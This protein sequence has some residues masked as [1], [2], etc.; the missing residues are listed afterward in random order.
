MV[1]NPNKDLIEKRSRDEPTGEVLPLTSKDMSTRMGD[2]YQRTRPKL[3]DED[4]QQQQAKKAAKKKAAKA[5]ASEMG[6][7]STST[8]TGGASGSEKKFKGQS[9]LSDDFESLSSILYRPKTYETRQSYEIILSFILE[10]IGDQPR[11]I[12]CGAADEILLILKNDRLRD[13]ERKREVES[14]L[15]PLADERFA[16]LVNLGKKLTDWSK[17]SI[18]SAAAAA[19]VANNADGGGGGDLSNM[20]ETIGVK[21]MIG[22]EDEDEDEDNDLYEVNENQEE[23]DADGSGE[24]ADQNQII[25]GTNGSNVT[26]SAN[27]QQQQH[28]SGNTT[29]QF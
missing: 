3:L 11:D 9:I 2:K 20:D 8:S 26:K 21:V 16:Q 18:E 29:T 28:G 23:D 1:I 24:E 19:A 6:D 10:C 13:K 22:D 25:H 15:G 12:L 4:D 5:S 14:L 7:S 27:S 17:E